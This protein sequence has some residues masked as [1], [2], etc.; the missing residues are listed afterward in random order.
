MGFL[1]LFLVRMDCS[2]GLM[3]LNNCKV[4]MKANGNSDLKAPLLQNSDSLAITISELDNKKNEKIR[5]I[6]FRVGGIECASCATSIESALGKLNG[7]RSVVVS[8][9]QGQAVIKYVPELINVSCV[10]FCSVII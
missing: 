1:F 4:K 8:P 5:T 9:L 3:N 7:V 10:L 2:L 6:M